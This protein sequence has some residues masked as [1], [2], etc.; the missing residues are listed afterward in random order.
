MEGT[1]A[2]ERRLRQRA[3]RYWPLAGMTLTLPG[4]A[5]PYSIAQPAFPDDLLDE[6]AARPA[7][8]ILSRSAVRVPANGHPILRAAA[9]EARRKVDSGGHLPYWGLLWPS[10][11]ALAEELLHAGA[12]AECAPLPGRWAQQAMPLQDEGRDASASVVSAHKEEGP[13]VRFSRALELGCGL[14]V[15][16]TAALDAGLALTAADCFPEALAFCRYNTLRNLGWTPTTRL[17]DWRT[18]TGRTALT[19]A[20]PY[21][22]LL[23]ADVLYEEPDSA[24]LLELAPQLVG[25]GG[26]F[27]LAE[28]GR[29]VSLRFVAEALARGW[30]D[31]PMVY[32]R[33]WPPDGEYA[34]VTV[35]RFLVA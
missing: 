35:H 5:R 6:L 23:A 14:G 8:A 17:V 34:R 26:H 32:E 28:P 19:L 33:L 18:E 13:G 27:W 7:R 29:R 21:D 4:A 30:E 31:A 9:T 2:R 25:P 1:N 24:L 10:G 15:T 22:L 11:L 16:A 3:R 20:A 12:V